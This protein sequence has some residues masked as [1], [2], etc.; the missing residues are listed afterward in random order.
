MRGAAISYLITHQLD[1]PA[2]YQQVL[3]A[4]TATA[5]VLQI[6]VVA[7]GG[8]RHPDDAAA[9]RAFTAHPSIR[10]R[11]A[12]YT[13]WL[14]LDNTSK[15]DIAAMALA[16]PAPNIKKLAMLMVSRHG[17]VIPLST[18]CTHFSS[19]Q[20]WPPLMR[21]G[22]KRSLGCHRSGRPDSA[23]GKS[24]HPRVFARQT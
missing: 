20:D 5:T 2:P 15:D 4:G 16:D 23:H 10:L 8:M 17:A 6:C 3:A 7:L 1:T 18:A 21:L 9:V 13:A 12:A 24:G 22:G 11:A 14:K 19:P